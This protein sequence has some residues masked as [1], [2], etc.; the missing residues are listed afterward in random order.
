MIVAE[1]NGKIPSKLDNSEDILTSNVFSFFKYADRQLFKEYLLI[2]GIE[3]SLIESKNAEFIFWPSYDDGTEPDLIVLCGKYYLLF[4]AKLYS[5]FSPKTSSTNSQIEREIEMGKMS[6]NN[7]NKEFVYVAIT[8]EYYKNKTKYSEH[9]NEDFLFIWTNW[10]LVASFLNK[11]LE[12]SNLKQ[13]EEFARD[14][15]SLLVKKKLRSFIGLCKIKVP[16]CTKLEHSIFYNIMTSKFKG[17]FSG[18]MDKLDGF[19]KI[20]PYQ[21]K[22]QNK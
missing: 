5:D 15:Y 2:L 14:L 8:A 12:N 4:E 13:D 1:I 3:I 9:E 6:A 20:M 16:D 11:I 21:R 18:Y 22:F 10:Q 17:E 19:E 7:F